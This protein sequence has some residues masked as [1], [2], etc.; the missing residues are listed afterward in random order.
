MYMKIL[1]VC[2]SLQISFFFRHFL[3]F[4]KVWAENKV[5]VS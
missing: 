4:G 2:V 3:Q 1:Y 5:T